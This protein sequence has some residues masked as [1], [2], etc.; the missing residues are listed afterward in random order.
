MK[1]DIVQMQKVSAALSK[2][3]RQLQSLQERIEAISQNADNIG[4][5]GDIGYR[6]RKQAEEVQECVKLLQQADQCLSGSISYYMEQ[7]VRMIDFLDETQAVKEDVPVG[8][9]S[10]PDWAF[11]FLG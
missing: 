2:C 10:I 3:P 5:L 11:Q 4:T 6:L 8:W 9:I 1:A 7:E